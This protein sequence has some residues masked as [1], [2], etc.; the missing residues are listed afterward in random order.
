MSD[1]IPKAVLFSGAGLAALLLIY[2][3]LSR[4][5]YFTSQTYL[6]GLILLEFLIAAVWFYDRVFPSRDYC[7]FPA[8]R[9]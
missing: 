3:A 5:G 1:R 4:P 7:G 6:G 8:G 9:S 2:A